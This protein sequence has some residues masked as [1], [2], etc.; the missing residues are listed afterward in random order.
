VIGIT[1]FNVSND[2]LCIELNGTFQNL[3]GHIGKLINGRGEKKYLKACIIK[4]VSL[5]FFFLVKY[6][7]FRILTGHG[8]RVFSLY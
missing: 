2:P 1:Y 8:F 6:F 4:D 3:L 5:F 7:H